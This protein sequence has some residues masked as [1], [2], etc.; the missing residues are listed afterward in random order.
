MICM[1]YVQNEEISFKKTQISVITERGLWALACA[2]HKRNEIKSPLC[3]VALCLLN[4]DSLER[5]DS[6]ASRT[7]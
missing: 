2:L 1:Q 6:N 3:C 7:W 4:N 5:I